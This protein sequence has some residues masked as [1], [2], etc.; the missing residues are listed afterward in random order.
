MHMSPSIADK[1]LK[2][3]YPRSY[4]GLLLF[5]QAQL[6]GH[7]SPTFTKDRALLQRAEAEVFAVLSKSK[8]KGWH[9]SALRRELGDPFDLEACQENIARITTLPPFDI[10]NGFITDVS[11]STQRKDWVEDEHYKRGMIVEDLR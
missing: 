8:E 1:E 2:K 7:C 4:G 5:Y 10:R 9:D 11:A 6:S 3:Q